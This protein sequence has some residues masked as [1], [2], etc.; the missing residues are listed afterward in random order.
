MMVLC[1]SESK[2]SALHTPFH[3]RIDTRPFR[4]EHHHDLTM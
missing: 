2:L 4:I 1:K 3:R